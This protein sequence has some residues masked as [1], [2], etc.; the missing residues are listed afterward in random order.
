MAKKKIKEEK[1]EHPLQ[2]TAGRPR[3]FDSPEDFAEQVQF[4][5]N[6]ISTRRAKVITV[7][8]SGLYSTEQLN[9]MTD[10]QKNAVI[11]MVD[12]NGNPIIED[13]WIKPPDI[14]GLQLFLGMSKQSW[15]DYG[16]DPRFSDI[17]TH[18]RHICEA[19]LRSEV[20]GRDT[21]TNGLKFMM[22][23]VYGYAEKT[24][25]QVEMVGKLE[26]DIV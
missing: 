26:D 25:V 12:N 9:A 6:S 15:S 8:Q 3:H 13:I 22:S 5:F 24:A 20:I 19:Y 21:S 14:L 16:L 17:V 23:S 1:R 2:K 10:E 4:Y 7:M 18:A 11:P